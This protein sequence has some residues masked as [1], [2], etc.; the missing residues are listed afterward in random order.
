MRGSIVDLGA[1]VI[2]SAWYYVQSKC[3]KAPNKKKTHT[4][5]TTRP[6]KNYKMLFRR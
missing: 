4:H 2:Q 1:V 5:R 3:S 6:K